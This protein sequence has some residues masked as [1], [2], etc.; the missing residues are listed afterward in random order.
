M[1]RQIY[2]LRRA[3]K[4]MNIG[5]GLYRTVYSL[6]YDRRWSEVIEHLGGLILGNFNSWYDTSSNDR[7]LAAA[8]REKY[9]NIILD[10]KEKFNNA[11]WET[12]EQHCTD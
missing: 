11:I 1:N 7:V 4:V 9:R 3:S 2:E 8:G 6:E 12:L 10:D 5:D